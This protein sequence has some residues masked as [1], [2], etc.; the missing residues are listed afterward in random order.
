MS[1]SRNSN[2]DI[3]S[4]NGRRHS[5]SS[6]K[7]R[8]SLSEHEPEAVN[9]DDLAVPPAPGRTRRLF[10][11]IGG[12]LRAAPRAFLNGL[13]IAPWV[14]KEMALEFVRFPNMWLNTFPGF[15]MG[16]LGFF[17][18]FLTTPAIPGILPVLSEEPKDAF[19]AINQASAWIKINMPG[20]DWL[21]SQITYGLGEASKWLSKVFK[22]ATPILPYVPFIGLGISA[23]M[24]VWD[25]WKS[26]NK[27]F[28]STF[29]FVTDVAGAVLLGVGLG[30]IT[31][32]AGAAL[33]YTAP[34]L[35]AAAAVVVAATGLFKTCMHF[36]KAVIEPEHRKDH[37]LNGVKELLVTVIQSAAAALSF[38]GMQMGQGVASGLANMDWS[39]ANVAQTY[40]SAAI[41]TDVV[42]AAGGA[43]AGIALFQ[44]LYTLGKKL[45]AGCKWLCKELSVKEPV[46]AEE[47]VA[48]EKALTKSRD[49]MISDL[50]NNIGRLTVEISQKGISDRLNAAARQ[51]KLDLLTVA[52]DALNDNA[53][54]E[55]VQEFHDAVTT[56]KKTAHST[57]VFRSF[58]EPLKSKTLQSVEETMEH[59]PAPAPR[60]R[61]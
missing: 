50:S 27:N 10:R 25:F 38:M 55:K 2:S 49:A 19:W 44:G 29:K 7:D 57:G 61:A 31:W 39:F 43:L 5:L 18:N 15:L 40:Q 60:A 46:V 12:K 33:L 56:A 13:L 11:W 24:S 4:D 17:R 8:A 54:P 20:L 3:D 14:I 23:S 6:A 35:I 32:G 1:G 28:V 41:A 48:V 51:K 26:E 42:L 30:L 59:I 36:Y 22:F 16:S 37:L 21:F 52:R 34:A 9:N 53:T 47:A 45:Y 58:W